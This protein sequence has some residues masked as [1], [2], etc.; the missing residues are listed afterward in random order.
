MMG[1]FYEL[2]EVL[3]FAG[4]GLLIGFGV[5]D[6]FVDWVRGCFGV[7]SGGFDIRYKFGFGEFAECFGGFW[8]GGCVG[9]IKK[10]IES[11]CRVAAFVLD[12]FMKS[13]F[14]S[15]EVGIIGVEVDHD[16]VVAESFE[17]ILDIANGVEPSDGVGENFSCLCFFVD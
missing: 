15:S 9:K 6:G 12:D 3:A 4:K 5:F 11:A 7:Y 17:A 2:D 8:A 10:E 13:G 16:E 14:L 1:L